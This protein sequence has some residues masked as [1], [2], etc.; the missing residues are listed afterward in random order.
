MVLRAVQDSVSRA[1][2]ATQDDVD[3]AVAGVADLLAAAKPARTHAYRE[4]GHIVPATVPASIADIPVLPTV[5]T[6]KAPSEAIASTTAKIS[7]LTGGLGYSAALQVARRLAA[8]AYPADT[9]TMSSHR[10]IAAFGF[11]E[12]ISGAELPPSPYAVERVPSAE[13]FG[14]HVLQ[15]LTSGWGTYDVHIM[16]GVAPE[17]NQ[18]ITLSFGLQPAAARGVQKLVARIVLWLLT[19]KGSD[20]LDGDYGSKL[21]IPAS[22]SNQ[23]QARAY[24]SSALTDMLY[25]WKAKG[26]QGLPP[27]ERLKTIDVLSVVARPGGLMVRVKVTTQ[28]GSHVDAVLPVAAP[29]VTYGY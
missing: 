10:G 9:T 3:R 16:Q 21:F 29:E 19:R 24:V 23:L 28:A 11:G 14:M 18:R 1:T 15:R 26:D 6:R 5:A 13:Y 8:I 25:A 27:D 20:L 17:G 7:E 12:S 22:V 2:G 4:P